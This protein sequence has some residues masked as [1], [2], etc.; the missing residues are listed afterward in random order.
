MCEVII[1]AADEL[2]LSELGISV[3]GWLGKGTWSVP[4]ALPMAAVA[5]KIGLRLDRAA[6]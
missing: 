2:A 1:A 6:R 5:V 3:V 4:W